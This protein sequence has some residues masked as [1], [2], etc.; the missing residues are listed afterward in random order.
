MKKHDEGYILAF[1][2]IVVAVLA[3]I[4]TAVSTVAVRN[5]ETQQN[6]VVRM[7]AKY[8]AE[9]II[10]AVLAQLNDSTFDHS[11]S[12]E[13]AFKEKIEGICSSAPKITEG[14]QISVNGLEFEPISEGFI[15][16]LTLE[17]L[18]ES[19]PMLSCPIEVKG[20]ITDATK[21][22][23]QSYSYLPIEEDAA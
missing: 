17:V 16:K 19:E 14:V 9:G 2:L 3:L 1:V 7:Q 18:R 6:A 15:C 11:K 20:R 21:I 23:I 4:S 12:A 5:I 10:E 22:D 13:E 8:E